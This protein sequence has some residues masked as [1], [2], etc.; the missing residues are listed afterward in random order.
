MKWFKWFSKYTKKKESKK[1]N[2]KTIETLYI[3][4]AD[5]SN[6][7]EKIK[8]TKQQMQEL[9]YVLFKEKEVQTPVCCKCCG[10]IIKYDKST[11]LMFDD[12]MKLKD[13]K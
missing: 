6:Y 12:L 3:F 11:L 13:D 1:I 7:Q 9:N 8:N 10:Q 4:F 5:E 2:V